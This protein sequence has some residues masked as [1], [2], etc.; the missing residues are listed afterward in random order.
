MI[1]E[2]WRRKNMWIRWIRIRIHNTASR[3]LRNRICYLT[4]GWPLCYPLVRRACTR[5]WAECARTTGADPTSSR[6]AGL[7]ISSL[8]STA[9][10][11]GTTHSTSTISVSVDPFKETVALKIW[12]NCMQLNPTYLFFQNSLI[13]LEALSYCYHSKCE[14]FL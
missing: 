5:V 12:F 13:F 8:G 9:P 14:V 4:S 2:S 6:P 1:E 10:C 11:P 3:T 7:P